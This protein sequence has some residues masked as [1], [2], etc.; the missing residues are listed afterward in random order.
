MLNR[1]YRQIASAVSSA[2]DR[3]QRMRAVVD[4]LWE[5]L[6]ET[7]VSWVG[8][9]LP[10][11]E[12]EL[13]LGPSRNTPACSPIGLHGVCGRA[14]TQRKAM[15]VRDVRDMGENYV[16]CDPRD[17]SELVVPV[18]DETGACWGVLDL[19]SHQIGAFSERDVA[20]L[21]SVLRAAGLTT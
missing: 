1:D 9:Y 3:E 13:V 14:F 4:A 15:I 20:G 10:E 21:Q 5:H 17:Q 12:T 19:D 8:F 7:G 11:G 2:G 6:H 18:F 16:A